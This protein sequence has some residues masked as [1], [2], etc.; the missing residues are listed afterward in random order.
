MIVARVSCMFCQ[1]DFDAPTDGVESELVWMKFVEGYP[2]AFGSIVV[3][4]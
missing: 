4:M 2:Q 1:K 3:S